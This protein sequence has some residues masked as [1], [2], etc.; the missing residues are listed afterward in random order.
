MKKKRKKKAWGLFDSDKYLREVFIDEKP[1]PYKL[2]G[3]YVKKVI[4]SWEELCA[5]RMAREGRL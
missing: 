4:I 3:W 1:I 2:M 5:K